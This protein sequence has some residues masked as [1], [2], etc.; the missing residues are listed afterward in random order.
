MKVKEEVSPTTSRGWNSRR[1]VQRA[2]VGG[3]DAV[4]STACYSGVPEEQ[5]DSNIIIPEPAF[6]VEYY[7]IAIASRQE[8]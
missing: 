1:R 3:A 8:I 2:K 6:T 7:G 5:S 4:I